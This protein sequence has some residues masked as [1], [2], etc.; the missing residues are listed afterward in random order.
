MFRE[1]VVMGLVFFAADRSFIV[2]DF[3][4]RSTVEDSV[5]DLY[6]SLEGYSCCR[7]RQMFQRF[8]AASRKCDIPFSSAFHTFSFSI[9]VTWW[10]LIAIQNV[11]WSVLKGEATCFYPPPFTIIISNDFLSFLG[12]QWE[13]PSTY[14]LFQKKNIVFGNIPPERNAT[15]VH[16]NN[17]LNLVIWSNVP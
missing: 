1:E 10:R 5:D 4:S 9:M 6:N 13:V 14:R 12:I 8:T 17:L 15:R 2:L 11:G 7:Q 3:L 16:S